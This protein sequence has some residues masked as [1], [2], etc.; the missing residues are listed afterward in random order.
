MKYRVDPLPDGLYVC[1]DPREGRLFSSGLTYKI[2]DGIESSLHGHGM[3]ACT[4]V[5]C[6][7]MV[8]IVAQYKGGVI[9]TCM[10]IIVVQYRGG[11]AGGGRGGK[12]RR[13]PP[14][15]TFMT[16]GPYPLQIQHL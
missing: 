8:I 10:V 2:N 6:T 4:H 15:P 5:I 1:L 13:E 14:P 16:G 7:C 11:G 9:C 3:Y 12:R